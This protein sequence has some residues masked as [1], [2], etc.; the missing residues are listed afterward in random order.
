[1]PITSK[2]T[3][4]TSELGGLFPALVTSTSGFGR[5]PVHRPPLV[6]PHLGGWTPQAPCPRAPPTAVEWRLLSAGILHQPCS[7][8]S[9][10]RRSLGAV[11]KPYPTILNCTNSRRS[12]EWYQ[13]R[14]LPFIGSERFCPEY[15]GSFV[16][17][18]YHTKKFPAIGPSCRTIKEPGSA[19]MNTAKLELLTASV[20]SGLPTGYATMPSGTTSAVHLLSLVHS[21]L[22]QYISKRMVPGTMQ[23]DTDP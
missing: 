20:Q 21:L 4:S 12:A 6:R 23:E 18:R 9:E 22:A 16:I 11:R 15:K 19:Y 13:L 7:S 14:G 8:A 10:E 2:V 3:I 5:P 17:I 1:M